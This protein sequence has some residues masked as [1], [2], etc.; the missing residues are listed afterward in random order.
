M[1]QF[2]QQLA[3]LSMW[4]NMEKQIDVFLQKK[5]QAHFTY[6]D[7]RVCALLNIQWLWGLNPNYCPGRRGLKFIVHLPLNAFTS[8]TCR[9][10][11]IYRLWG[12][13]NL[14]YCGHWSSFPGI[15]LPG[16]EVNHSPPSSAEVKNEWGYTSVPPVYPH[17]VERKDFIFAYIAMHRGWRNVKNYTFFEC[18][19]ASSV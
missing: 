4:T 12:P 13:P 8:R 14:L 19:K 15:K 16:R 11:E 2:V 10:S 17:G 1:K 18:T 6:P 3:S 9:Y 7:L 5:N